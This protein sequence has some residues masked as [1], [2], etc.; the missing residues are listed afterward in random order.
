MK[1]FAEADVRRLLH[2]K[3]LID[4]METALAE[5]S[6]GKVIQPVRT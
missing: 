3:P 4:A 2:W 1:F 6:T 5:F